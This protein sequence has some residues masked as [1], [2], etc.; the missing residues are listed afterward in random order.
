MPI[1][2]HYA[3]LQVSRNASAE[4]IDRAY[5][6]LSKA[7]DPTTSRKPRASQRHSDIREAYEVLGDRDKR[8]EYDRT[9]R[10]G[11]REVAGAVSPSDVLSNRFV[12]VGAGTLIASIAAIVGVILLFGGGGDDELVIATG[13]PAPTP[14]ASPTPPANTPT[15]PPESPPEVAGEEVTLPSGLKYIDV[16]V[17]T[18]E[19][20]ELRDLVAVNYTGWL[21]DTGV[22]FDSSLDQPTAFNVT[23]GS[24]TIQGWVEGL[25]GM[26]EGGTR[27]LI[28]PPEL[29]YG[30]AGRGD[31]IPPN[32]TLIF[33]ITLIDVL[34]KGV[35]P[36]PTPAP[37]FTPIVQTPGTAPESPPEIT[38]EE[39]TL[40]SGL[41]YIDF[42]PG[43]GD[44]AATGDAVAVNY[45]GWTEAT[46]VK[47]DSSVDKSAP[48][49]LTIGTGTIQGWIE[50]LPGMKEGGKR[51]LIIPAALAY[52]DVGS[53]ELIPPGAT[54][55]FD[56]ELVD[57]LQK[58]PVATP[59]GQV[60]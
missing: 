8:R 49:Q 38:G 54:L 37:A 33:D 51:R 25:P 46:G 53:G 57:I 34:A 55:I 24:G 50:G 31:T 9:L 39:I 52:K 28:I 41:K 36:T 17:G 7:Y 42:V 43:T 45:T 26:K 27:R 10:K 15:T 21:Q 44:T 56:I 16:V 58:A 47:F 11:D 6:R 35:G 29:G 14:T 12:W 19:T 40:P 20:A 13:T 60:P 3:T 4:D 18:G 22:K 30:E 1:R 5:E 48:Y 32:S 23:I 59:G 2:D